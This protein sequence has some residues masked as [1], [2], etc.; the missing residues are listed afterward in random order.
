[1]AK[2]KLNLVDDRVIALAE[3]LIQL[4]PGL[5]REG[6]IIKLA[7]EIQDTIDRWFREMSEPA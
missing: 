2:R 1:M 3:Q 6:A 7:T 4:P 5:I